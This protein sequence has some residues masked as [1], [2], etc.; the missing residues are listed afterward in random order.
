MGVYL[1]EPNTEKNS[2]F[3]QGKLLSYTSAEM[4]GIFT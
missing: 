2:K 1:S 3:E 4:Q